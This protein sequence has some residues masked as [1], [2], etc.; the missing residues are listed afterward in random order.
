[1]DGDNSLDG[2][3]VQDFNEMAKVGSSDNVTVVVLLDRRDE[4]ASIYK[5]KKGVNLDKASPL[6]EKGEVDMGD[7]D[8]LEDFVD[9]A[10]S[11]FPAE[12]IALVF[13]NHGDGWRSV[14]RNRIGYKAASYDEDDYH[15]KRKHQILKNQQV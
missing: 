11:Q 8:T 13:W 7:P 10:V 2:A 5:V 9:Y 1:M 6:V 12:K 3:T 4:G 15:H 14:K